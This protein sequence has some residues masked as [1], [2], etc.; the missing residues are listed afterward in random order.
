M[1]G[2]TFESMQMRIKTKPVFQPVF[3]PVIDEEREQQ[4]HPHPERKGIDWPA[5]GGVM[6]F[7][8]IPFFVVFVAPLCALGWIVGKLFPE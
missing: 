7:I 8:V 1:M 3:Q 2:W 4:P 6:G 5:L